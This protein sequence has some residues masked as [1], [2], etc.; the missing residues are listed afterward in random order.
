MPDEIPS[1]ACWDSSKD[2]KRSN[3]YVDCQESGAYKP[4]AVFHSIAPLLFRQNDTEQ[5]RHT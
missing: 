4:K 5:C 1:V 3:N 2:Y